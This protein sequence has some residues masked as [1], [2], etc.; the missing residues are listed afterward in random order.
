MQIDDFV[1][2]KAVKLNILTYNLFG[3]RHVNSCEKT[4]RSVEENQN[5]C[6]DEIYRTQRA[7]AS[8]MRYSTVHSP[9]E[10]SGELDVSVQN[11]CV[12]QQLQ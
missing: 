1:C 7:A 5:T 10:I 3:L 2:I 9:D 6:S 12:Y 11:S 4:E 8:F